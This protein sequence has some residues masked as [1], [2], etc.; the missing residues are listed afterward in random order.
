MKTNRCI[1]KSKFKDG[2]AASRQRAAFPKFLKLAA[3]CR[4]AATVNWVFHP[5]CE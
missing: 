5:S 1:G 4:D 3:L 2:V